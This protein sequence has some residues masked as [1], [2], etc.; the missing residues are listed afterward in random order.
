MNTYKVTLTLDPKELI[1]FIDFGFAAKA[2]IEPILDTGEVQGNQHAPIMSRRASRAP[3]GSK[4]NDAILL[5]LQ[6]GERSSKEL[7]KVLEG[8]GLAAGSLSAGL[9]V[10]Q[11]QGHIDRVSEGVYALRMA[12]AAE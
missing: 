2:T 4:V 7:R 11:R 10:L 9:A 1:N 12:K 5:A 3:R 6:G 8:A